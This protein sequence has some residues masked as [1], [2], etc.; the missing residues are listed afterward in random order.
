MNSELNG[1]FFFLLPSSLSRNL[2]ENNGLPEKIDQSSIILSFSE[3]LLAHQGDR[4]EAV[5]I[6]SLV[7]LL[8]LLFVPN[9]F[10]HSSLFHY[11]TTVHLVGMRHK[12]SSLAES[13]FASA[14]G[15]RQLPCMA[16]HVSLQVIA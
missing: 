1:R 5:L 4:H 16:F 14:T 15:K 7:T 12:L 13:G 3:T 8:S 6:R 11:L 2:N 10:Y 9:C